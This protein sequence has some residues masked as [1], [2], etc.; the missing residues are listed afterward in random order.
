MMEHE[1]RE[2]FS[3]RGNLKD[4]ICFAGKKTWLLKN[5]KQT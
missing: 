3:N 1:T 2:E 5:M 4:F